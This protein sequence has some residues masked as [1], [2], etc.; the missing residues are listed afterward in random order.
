MPYTKEDIH[1][2]IKW[3]HFLWMVP[4][5]FRKLWSDTTD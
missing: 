4:R 5:R 2:E 3:S 1:Q